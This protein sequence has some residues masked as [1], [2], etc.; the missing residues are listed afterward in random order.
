MAATADFI[1]PAASW[2]EWP[3]FNDPAGSSPQAFM[4]ATAD[5]IAPAASWPEWPGF[6][7][8]AS[9]SPQA[10]KLLWQPQLAL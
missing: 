7:D 5:F 9:S 1:A 3:G 10:F 8:S 2:P 4:A 6:S